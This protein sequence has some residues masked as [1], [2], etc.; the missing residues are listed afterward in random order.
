PKE[1]DL[2]RKQCC[3]LDNRLL[4]LF[5]GGSQV[6]LPPLGG[7]D[8]AVLARAL[9]FQQAIITQRRSGAVNI[10]LAF[11]APR[12]P[13]LLWPSGASLEVCIKFNKALYGSLQ[14]NIGIRRT[15]IPLARW[16]RR[17]IGHGYALLRQSLHEAMADKSQAPA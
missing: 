12:V 7:D 15:A 8:I 4:R 13:N 9:I 10:R 2:L 6:R 1:C 3:L 11:D 5:L 17:C 14:W 16:W